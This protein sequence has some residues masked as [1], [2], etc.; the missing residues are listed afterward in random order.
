MLYFKNKPFKMLVVITLSLL[1]IS[2]FTS[3]VFAEDVHGLSQNPFADISASDWFYDDV[4]YVWGNGLMAGVDETEF[5]PNDVLNRGM[6]VTILWRLEN[7]PKPTAENVFT[8]LTED[9]YRGAVLWADEHQIIFGYGDGVFGPEDSVTR[10]QLVTMLG[11][12]AETFKNADISSSANLAGY[13]DITELSGWAHVYMSWARGTGIIDGK[14]VSTLAPKD[15]AT[16]AET[17]AAL[18][19]F[20]ESVK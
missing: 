14:N 2:V 16:R 19:R 12:Y 7:S 1:Y 9:W 13:E 18:H 10:E 15:T 17:A 20:L 8:D 3:C 6:L 5:K 4:E 11:R